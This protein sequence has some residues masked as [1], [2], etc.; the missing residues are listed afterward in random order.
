MRARQNSRFF[1]NLLFIYL[2]NIPKWDSTLLKMDWI[3]FLDDCGGLIVDGSARQEEESESRLINGN[4]NK[5]VQHKEGFSGGG[6]QT[7]ELVPAMSTL[8]LRVMRQRN[9]TRAIQLADSAVVQKFALTPS[10]AQQQFRK[11]LFQFCN[12]GFCYKAALLLD[13]ILRERKINQFAHFSS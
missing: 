13:S 5:K 8:R 3:D 2:L 9:V 6:I 1:W 7:T 11:I 4:K 12:K 10:S